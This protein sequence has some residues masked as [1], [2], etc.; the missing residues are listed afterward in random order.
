MKNTILVADDESIIL[1]VL[2]YNLENSGYNVLIATNGKEALELAFKEHP[3]LIILDI[4]M[5]K[6]NGYEVCSILKSDPKTRSIPIIMLTAMGEDIDGK[7]GLDSGADVYETKPF[8]PK[9]LLL[10]VKEFL[11]K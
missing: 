5:P 1:R 2:K 4:L 6:V 3:D 9:S 8:S 7:K 10:K 11:E